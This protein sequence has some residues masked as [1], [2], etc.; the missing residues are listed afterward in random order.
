[1]DMADLAKRVKGK[2][3]FW[4]E[5]DRQHVL[6]SADTQVARNAVREVAQHLYDPAGGIIAQFEL[7][8]GANPAN[9]FAIYD[10]WNAIEQE[11]AVHR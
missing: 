8:P 4:G 2:I 7:G 9:A 3:T 11:A 6:P 10:E 1:M 5:I